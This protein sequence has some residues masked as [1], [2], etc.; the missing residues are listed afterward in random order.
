MN[1]FKVNDKD[2][3]AKPFD[4]NMICDLEDMGLSLAEVAEKPMSTVR[5]YFALCTGK[6]KEYAGLEM[7]EHIIKGGSF[8]AVIEAMNKEMEKSDFFRNL[9]KAEETKVTKASSKAK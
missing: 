5:A 9:T 6:G 8:D 3:I 7:G 2:Y 1:T 4:F